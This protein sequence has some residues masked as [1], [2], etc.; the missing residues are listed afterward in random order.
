LYK[1]IKM[2]MNYK[3]ASKIVQL[4]NHGDYEVNFD[5]YFS[6]NIEFSE[7]VANLLT[8]ITA[9]SSPQKYTL[10]HSFIEWYVYAYL[11]FERTM[12]LDDAEN[13]YDEDDL[14]SFFDRLNSITEILVEYDAQVP[15]YK[16]DFRDIVKNGQV[17]TDFK[18]E[19]YPV[20]DSLLEKVDGFESQFVED[21]FYM[22]YSNKDFLYEFNLFISKYIHSDRIPRELFENDKVKR[23]TYIPQWLQRAVFFRDRGKCQHCGK[24]MSNLFS[25]IGDGELQLDHIIPLDKFG[26]NDATNFQLLCSDCNL[27]KSGKLC[28]PLYKYESFW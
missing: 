13:V 26:T 24:D 15:E 6:I 22:L 2:G 19:V 4:F 17:N 5:K 25:I 16:E 7:I 1:P 3:M 20:I 21:I 10:L 11:L 14:D 12:I 9:I 18:Q 23:C 28:R 8:N 27:E